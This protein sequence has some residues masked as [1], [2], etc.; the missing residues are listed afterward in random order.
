MQPV[1]PESNAATGLTLGAPQVSRQQWGQVFELLDT[2]LELDP[3]SRPAW[4]DSLQA[5]HAQLSP[6]LRDLLQAHARVGTDDFLRTP[7]TFVFDDVFDGSV[8]GLVAAQQV[9]AQS[10]VGPYRLLR[11]IGQGGMASVWLAERADGLLERRVALKLPHVSWGA[12]TFADRMGRERNILASLTHPNIARLYDAGVA[13]DGR[14]YLALEYVDGEPIDAY[15]KAHGL[16]VRA[17]VGLIVQVARAVAHAHARLVVHRDLKPSNILVDAAGQTHLLDFGIAKLM[18]PQAGDD[19]QATQAF[20]R[21]LTPDYASPEQIRGDAIA[22]ASD[23]YSLAVVM[24]ELLAGERPYRLGK[25]LGAVALAEAVARADVPNASAVASDPALRRQ[26][27]GDLDAVLSM[28][29]AKS[30]GERYRT[31]DALADDL[32]RHLRGEPVR[33]RPHSRWYHVRRW[34]GRHKVESGIAAALPVAALSGAYAQALVLVALAAGAML[35]LWQR[36]RARQQT[37]HARAALQRAEQ[38][39]SFIGSIFTEAVPRAGRGGAVTATDLLH[40]A[41]RRVTHDLADQPEVA[42]EL[43]LLIGAGF[44]QLGEVRAGLDWLPKVV[45]Q[46]SRALGPTHLLSLQS[47]WRLAEAANS[48][49]E[50]AVAQAL[51]PALVNDLRGAQPAA[52]ALLASAL[53][54][55]AYVLTKRGCEAEAMA[56]LHEAVDIASGALGESHEDTLCA[57]ASLSNTCVHFGRFAEALATIEPALAVARAAFAHQRPHPMLLTV[58][59]NHADALA[60]NDRP[61]DAT[62]VLRQVLLDQRALDVV[63]TNRVRIA[64]TLLAHA[65]MLGGHFDE[66]EALLIEALA[67]HERLTNGNNHEGDGLCVRL[68]IVCALQGD[69]AQGLLHL[70]YADVWVQASSEAQ[71]LTF[72]REAAR[73][74]AQVVAGHPAL[75]LATTEAML[76]P[77]AMASHAAVRMLRVRAMALRQL[78]DT[79]HASV[80]AEQAIAAAQHLHGA[81][82]ERGLAWAEAARCSLA[83]GQVLKAQQQFRAG[84]AAWHEAQVDGAALVVSLQL[85]LAALDDT[86]RP[87]TTT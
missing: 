46:S 42:A 78:G 71:V 56:A 48:V 2:A 74:L 38:V 34:V 83:A 55:L 33:A 70:S 58:E 23:I 59:R 68:A 8:D 47:R 50:V 35:A 9:A 84:L 14:P 80:A 53:R 3:A 30:G 25:G 52:P 64:M 41:A 49:G 6:L 86:L 31:M 37:E 28:A 57:R 10:L 87:N 15:A 43:G 12:A 27:A 72:N 51:L 62:V 36:N 66:S 5:E 40:A 32:E 24:F 60:R 21:A 67:M 44:N 65:L 22:T 20:S 17:R 82:L 19:A 79:H 39:K 1:A 13:E 54:S 69:G 61:R 18:D 76:P 4:L 16:S 7:P 26:L 81:G 11:E 63:E 45:E 85:E 29:L 73:A 75:A 77:G